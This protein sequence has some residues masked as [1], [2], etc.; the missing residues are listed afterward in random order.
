MSAVLRCNLEFA[1]AIVYCEITPMPFFIGLA[2]CFVVDCL[3]FCVCYFFCV[4]YVSVFVAG[5][6]ALFITRGKLSHMAT[7]SGLARTWCTSCVG[8][9]MSMLRLYQS[10]GCF[11]ERVS[12]AFLQKCACFSNFCSFPFIRSLTA[13][14]PNA[15]S[16]LGMDWRHDCGVNAGR[17]HGGC[18]FKICG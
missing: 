4:C 7:V 13:A 8:L 2:Y 11:L 10:S 16:I 17:W 3:C 12:V 14:A 15:V 9:R 1:F 18:S 5:E 6:I